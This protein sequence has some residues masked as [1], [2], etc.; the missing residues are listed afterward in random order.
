MTMAHNGDKVTA[1][2]SLEVPHQRGM[3]AWRALEGMLDNTILKMG[4]TDILHSTFTSATSSNPWY[5]V[6]GTSSLVR[7]AIP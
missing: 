5:Y 4:A 7:L 2:K 3:A 1:G 6:Y